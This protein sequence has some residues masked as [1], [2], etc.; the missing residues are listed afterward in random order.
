MYERIL[1]TVAHI[2]SPNETAKENLTKDIL[3]VLVLVRRIELNLRIPLELDLLEI[4][5]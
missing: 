2:V 1:I 3:L 4:L 5:K